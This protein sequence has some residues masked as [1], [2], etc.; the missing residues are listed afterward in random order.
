[1]VGVIVS[2]AEK[3][4]K[5]PSLAKRGRGSLATKCTDCPYPE[6]G[7]ELEDCVV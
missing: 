4:T 1:M 5:D 6:F 3:R 2:R 7:A